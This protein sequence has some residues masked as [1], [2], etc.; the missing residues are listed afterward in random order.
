MVSDR[1]FMF[2]CI[3]S[4]K[5]FSFIPSSRSSVKV[6][7]QGHIFQKNGRYRGI[8]IS[9]LTLYHTIPTVNDLGQ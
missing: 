9:H 5:T 2:I 7:D 3:P 8:S 4:G 6:K 1:T